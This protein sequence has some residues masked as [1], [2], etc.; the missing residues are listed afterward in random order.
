MTKKICIVSNK[1]RFEAVYYEPKERPLN[2][3]LEMPDGTTWN[4]Y[5]LLINSGVIVSW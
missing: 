2:C 1:N 3:V 5:Y 4:N